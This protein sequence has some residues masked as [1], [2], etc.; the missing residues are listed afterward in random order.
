LCQCALP[1]LYGNRVG[2]LEVLEI[3]EEP[4]EIQN[5]PARAAGTSESKESKSWCEVSKVPLN[6]WH[7]A[8]YLEIVYSKFLEVC[9]CGKVMQGASIKPLGSD[10]SRAMRGADTEPLDEW[11]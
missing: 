9:E 3:R 2:E 8:G 7:K 11:E 5:L 4:N 6:V 1:F 10:L